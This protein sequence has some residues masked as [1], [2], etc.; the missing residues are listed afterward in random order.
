[1]TSNLKVDVPELLAAIYRETLGDAT[2]DA[3]SDFFE[4]GGDSLAAFQITARIQ[5]SLG[6][7]VPVAL[8]FAYPS[9]ADLASVVDLEPAQG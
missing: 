7:E 3:G 9:P 1:M 2:L 6:V 4:A 5:E 8:V